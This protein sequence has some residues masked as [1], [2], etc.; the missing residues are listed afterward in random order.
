VPLAICTTVQVA[1]RLSDEPPG[2]KDRERNSLADEHRHEKRVAALGRVRPR[3]SAHVL[4]ET[5]PTRDRLNPRTAVT[6]MQ[7]MRPPMSRPSRT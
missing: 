6:S 7:A 5:Y 4:A 1:Q 3:Q 2:S